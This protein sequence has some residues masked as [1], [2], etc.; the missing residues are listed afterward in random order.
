MKKVPF[1]ILL[2][3]ELYTFAVRTAEVASGSLADKPYVVLLV[4]QLNAGTADLSIALGRALKSDFTIPLYLKDVTRD[5]SHKGFYHYVKAYQL[6]KNP[7][8]AAAAQSLIDILDEF[9]YTLYKLGYA[10]ETTQLNQLFV[11]LS[12]PQAT[13]WLQTLNG[14]EWLIDLK[15]SQAD[16]EATYQLKVSVEGDINL[17]LAKDSKDRIEQNLSAL[18]SYVESNTRFEAAT[19][20]PVKNKLNEIITDTV[21]IARARITRAENEA[22]KNISGETK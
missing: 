17:P 16:F 1:S 8:Q 11:R 13:E 20:T 18:L 4:E 15:E 7:A 9:G 3:G 5:N 6:S 12:T 21:A 14:T 10:E 22:K 19:Y 2:S